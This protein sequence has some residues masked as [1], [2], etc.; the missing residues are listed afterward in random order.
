ME[1]L[2]NKFAKGFLCKVTGAV[3]GKGEMQNFGIKQIDK[4]QIATIQRFSKLM[5]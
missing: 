4:G 5:F 1:I 3:C 2:Q